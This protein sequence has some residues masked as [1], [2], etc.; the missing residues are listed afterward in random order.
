MG[1]SIQ[2]V[3]SI[4]ELVVYI[5][6][7]VAAFIVCNRHGF[8]RGSGWIYTLIL[9][10]VRIIG[11][12][13]Q[14]VSYTNNDSS[15]IKTAL[16]LDSIG[17]FSPFSQLSVYSPAHNVD[18]TNTTAP[19]PLLTTKHFRLVQLLITLGLI[20]SIAGGTSDPDL[21]SSPTSS[22]PTSSSPSSDSDSSDTSSSS[23]TKA[24]PI[25]YLI[26]LLAIT[27]GLLIAWRRTSSIPRPKR[28]LAPAITLALPLIAVRLLYSILAAFVHDSNNTLSVVDGSVAVRGCMAL[29]EEVLVVGLYLGLGF[30]LGGIGGEGRGGRGERGD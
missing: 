5:P 30:V 13:C 12:A 15:L 24:A 17:L 20:L 27:L 26:S 28:K 25:L 29:V 1:F 3:V 11:A 6:C 4:I 23:T 8:R 2:G 10:L 7:L 22:S 19:H 21:S 16:I 18:T 14:Q 9:C